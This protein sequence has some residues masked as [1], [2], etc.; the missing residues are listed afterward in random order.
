MA[1][2]VHFEVFRRA[3]ARGT[4]TLHEVVSERERALGL[5]QEMMA[6][7]KATGVKVVKET[8]DEDTGDYLSLKIFED[9]HNKMKT[10]PAQEDA[11]PS[12][13]CFK[14]DDLYSYHAR[15]TMMRLLGDFLSRNR[16]TITELIHRA[17]MLDRLEAT[18]TV[19]QHAVQK[20]AVAQASSGTVP[21]Q[22][23]V[24]NLNEL[25]DQATQRV[26]RDQRKGLFPNPRADQFAE[27]AAQ[28]AGKGDAAY[29]FNGALAR[30]LKDAEGWNEKILALLEILAQAPQ[31]GEART[32]VLSSI[33]AI[34]AEAL[35]ASTALHE[36][37]GRAENLAEAMSRLVELFLGKS[38]TDAG[39]R[40][41]SALA[42]R[43]AADELPE[44]RTAIARRIVAEFKSAKRLRPDSLVEEL[45]AL[46]RLA[47]RVVYGVGKFL[48]HEDLI[49]AFT[50]RSKRL[51]TQET[52]SSHIS[53]CAPDEKLERLLF[54]EENIIG[55]ENK[56]QL[57][58]FVTPVLNSAAFENFC[59]NPKVPVLQRLKRL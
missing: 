39:H 56:R 18:G 22:Q 16:I 34:L 7:E 58:G 8:Y 51:V 40:G 1:R 35:S 48:S 53:E 52:L 37:I 54:V 55:I 38:G 29:L 24:K 43:F 42:A 32:L 3:G 57:A 47:N 59:Q 13:P 21:V 27:L 20:I 26:Y 44:A 41:L 9:G 19:Y 50:L 45:T 5:A 28:L 25:I 4:W 11:P 15:Q 36:L 12:L 49:A 31:T 6:S 23:I 2:Q 14:P 33:D 46:R 30:H 10:A 17:D